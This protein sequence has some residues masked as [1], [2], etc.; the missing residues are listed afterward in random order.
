[1]KRSHI[2]GVIT[3][4]DQNKFQGFP[5]K[6]SV[7]KILVASSTL[8]LF[9]ILF[10][11][12]QKEGSEGLL[13]LGFSTTTEKVENGFLNPEENLSPQT[14]TELKKARAATAKYRNINNAIADG[15]A[16]INV[17]VANMGFHYMKSTLADANFEIE[18][19]EILVYNEKE[20]G[21]I[22]LV[23]VEYAVPIPLT[24]NAAPQGFTGNNDV[25]TYS[26]QFNLWLLHAW[27]W[28]YN[29]AGVFNPTNPLVHQ[30]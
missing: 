28:E 30:H 12:C 17:V 10:S 2:N 26:T 25:W 4:I 29:P 14:I 8:C 22:D 24:P 23:A 13:N 27:V 7:R 11:G 1:M 3:N 18:K 21:R 6:F 20:N 5:K 9:A 19:P 16:D 15:Y